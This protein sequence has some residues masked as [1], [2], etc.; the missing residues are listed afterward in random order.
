[1]N[2]RDKNFNC[3][4]E[5]IRN[6]KY[7]SFNLDF[8]NNYFTQ[9][10]DYDPKFN[11]TK[12]F[13][14]MK[15][16]DLS[17]KKIDVKLDKSNVKSDTKLHKNTCCKINYC[18]NSDNNFKS[19]DDSIKNLDFNTVNISNREFNLV[20]NLECL[21]CFSEC[22]MTLLSDIFLVLNKKEKE[23]YLK[24]LKLKMGVEL[25]EKNYH[26]KFNYHK[27]R[28]KK[29]KLTS[30]LMNN[31]LLDLNGQKYLMDYFNINVLIYFK[32]HDEFKPYLQFDKNRKSVLLIHLDKKY[33][34][35]HC[36]NNYF[37]Q[38]NLKKIINGKFGKIYNP[39][40]KKLKGIGSYK[41]F[42]LQKMAKSSNIDI[43]KVVNGKD[44]KRTK[45][46][47]YDD[48]SLII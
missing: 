43:M 11:P 44:K 21:D 42:D 19:Q 29:S 25:D 34:P 31:L 3:V 17:G 48:L 40:G 20:N 46:E 4:I 27:K 39:F 1:M 13:D 12:L 18:F 45:K 9:K 7:K 47:L 10:I 2:Q 22:V 5:K 35:L 36:F 6:K 41:L 38:N 15:N 14:D 37:E 28:I 33:C 26:N 8:N 32:E 16:H 24:T 23:L 30:Q